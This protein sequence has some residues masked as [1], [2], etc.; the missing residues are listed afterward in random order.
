MVEKDKNIIPELSDEIPLSW[1]K[2]AEKEIKAR[3]RS[4]VIPEFRGEEN[5]ELHIYQPNNEVDGIASDHYARAYNRFLKDKDLMTKSEMEKLL[6]ERGLWTE[7]EETLIK[8]LQTDQEDIQFAVAKLRER[9]DYN[10]TVYEKHKKAWLA[11]R[12]KIQDLY[13]E[14]VK[15][16]SNTVEG[17]AEEEE[18]KVRLSLCVKYPD[19]KRVWNSFQEFQNESERFSTL[20]I[21]NEA[22]IFWNGLTQE[23]IDRLPIELAFGGE[24]DQKTSKTD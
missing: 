11:I 20:K 12:G 6:E 13:S 19:G 17:R 21:L 10:K 9:K 2:D 24:V 22:V 23:I 7:K 15:F 18:V 4:V 3:Y 16:F 5:V 8:D 14:K 1:L